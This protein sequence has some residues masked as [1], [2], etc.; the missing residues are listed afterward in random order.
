[1]TNE[2]PNFSANLPSDFVAVR[3]KQLF[4]L[5]KLA[6]AAHT[7]LREQIDD[8]VDSCE[9]EETIRSTATAQTPIEC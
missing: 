6:N 3:A 5:L 8:D 7:A 4:E 2:S 1:M 9:E